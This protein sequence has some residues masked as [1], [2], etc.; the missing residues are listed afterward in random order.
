M[1]SIKKSARKIILA[2]CVAGC[3]GFIWTNSV[4]PG[5]ISSE[6]SSYAGK[7][8]KMIFGESFAV[9]ETIIRKLAHCCEFGVFGLILSLFFY[10]RLAE[11]LPLV[12]FFGLGAAVLDETIQL[13]S[14]GR[15]SQI[16]DVW[17]DFSGFTAGT[18]FIFIIYFLD[19]EVKGKHGRL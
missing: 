17:I 19:K 1:I 7:I 4:M 9:S 15:S 6:F 11:R 12:G 10:E 2:L 13:F 14:D 18:L 16:K 3:L 5:S 8:L